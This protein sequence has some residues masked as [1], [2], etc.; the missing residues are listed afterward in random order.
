MGDVSYGDAVVSVGWNLVTIGF[1]GVLAWGP[2]VGECCGFGANGCGDAWMKLAVLF[3]AGY[4]AAGVA[5]KRYLVA[6]DGG[7]LV[8][9]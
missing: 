8:N 2:W 5:A 3:V 7:E 9:A 4:F 6:G 1:G